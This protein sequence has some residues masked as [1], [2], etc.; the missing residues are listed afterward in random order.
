MDRTYSAT[1]DEFGGAVNT[2]YRIIS[3]DGHTI[4]PPHMWETYPPRQVP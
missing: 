4:E 1:A 2:N 3:A